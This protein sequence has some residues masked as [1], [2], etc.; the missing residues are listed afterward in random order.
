MFWKVLSVENFLHLILSKTLVCV[1]G[2]ALTTIG[3]YIGA[4]LST[5]QKTKKWNRVQSYRL[6]TSSL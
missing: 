1:F 3:F 6:P 5:R 2:G 4:P